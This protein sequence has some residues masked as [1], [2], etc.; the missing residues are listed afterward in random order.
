M[1]KVKEL[2]S[3]IQELRACSDALTAIADDLASLF[4]STEEKQDEKLSPEEPQGST[5]AKPALRLEDV[6]AVLAEKSRAG[7]TAKVRELIAKYG[8]QRLSD[9]DPAKYDELL[10][11][12]EVLHA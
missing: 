12:A 2:A 10:S 4:M 8:A 5:K 7:L 6:R 11:E 9:V 1:A 3:I